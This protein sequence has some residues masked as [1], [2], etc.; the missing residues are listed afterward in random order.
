MYTTVNT[1]WKEMQEKN[2]LFIAVIFFWVAMYVYIP[3]QTTYLKAIGVASSQIGIIVGAYGISQM[4]LRYPVGVLADR[5]NFHKVFILLGGGSAAAASVFRI[6]LNNNLGFF[7]GNVLS[8]FASAMWISFM[9][10]YMRYYAEEEQRQATGKIVFA[11]NI[12]MLGGFIISSLLYQL[13]GM[14]IICVFS[15][16]AGLISFGFSFTLTAE[17]EKKQKRVDLQAQLALCHRKRLVL[18]S[19]LALVQQGIQ[20]ATAMS[21]SMQIVT[22]LGGNLKEVGISSMIYMFSAVLWA[23]VSTTKQC[24]KIPVRVLVSGIFFVNG[25]Y[26]LL[27]PEVNL[28]GQIYILQILPGMATG[29]LFSCLTAEAMIGIA[30][31]IKATAMGV[32]QTLYAVG[33]TIFPMIGGAIVQ[34][35]SMRAAYRVFAMICLGTG[36]FVV[37]VWK[38]TNTAGK[39]KMQTK[40]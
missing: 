7:I 21:F 29:L 16:L 5:Q 28:I 35:I 19:I 1:S 36:I 40:C 9:V 10:L 2:K 22:G 3:Y 37:F 20:A 13:V 32:Y 11:N 17:K 12:G 33:I 38:W 24:G 4:L 6:I 23:K 18:Y 31:E 14:Q 25:L 30:P 15:V 27:M 26:L 39:S 34:D 8:G